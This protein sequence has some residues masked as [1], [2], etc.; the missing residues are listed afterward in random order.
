MDPETAAQ[1]VLQAAGLAGHHSTASANSHAQALSSFAE[2]DKPRLGDGVVVGATSRPRSSSRRPAS[3]AELLSP[4]ATAIA[5]S[6]A[7]NAVA[8]SQLAPLSPRLSPA[9]PQSP[10]SSRQ[11][12]SF[13]QRMR[14][15]SDSVSRANQPSS[16]V[17]E[18]A[19][20]IPNSPSPSHRQLA[21]VTGQTRSRSNSLSG[22][23][24]PANAA[25]SSA[26]LGVS[27]LRQLQSMLNHAPSA[28]TPSLR[29]H[30]KRE[31]AQSIPSS[32][33]HS[34]SSHHHRSHRPA[35][36]IRI[37]RYTTNELMADK[38]QTYSPIHEPRNSTVEALGMLED[39]EQL[40]NGVPIS[41][42]R[43]YSTP[44]IAPDSHMPP[45]SSYYP[46]PDM[47]VHSVE[48]ARSYDSASGGFMAASDTRKDS[49]SLSDNQHDG[50]V[51]N[52]LRANSPTNKD[53]VSDDSS[54]SSDEPTT[55][56]KGSSHQ[57]SYNKSEMLRNQQTGAPMNLVVKHG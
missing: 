28:P 18:G 26:P 53:A 9:T 21:A 31:I 36:H 7:Q 8:N 12:R 19:V 42:T 4:V 5:A 11:S 51:Y 43:Q 2:A 33:S 20:H 22:T 23:S 56:F 13:F 3:S 34:S 24:S 47:T 48:S 39:D 14:P 1:I 16:R 54:N 10:D 17:A 25:H 45:V 55:Q 38:E 49:M 57:F 41:M 50:G 44:P 52:Q 30:N 37:D 46:D 35:S 32:S 29:T 40:V 6:I 15:R 27:E